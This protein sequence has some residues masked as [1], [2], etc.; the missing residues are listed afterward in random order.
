VSADPSIGFGNLLSHL[1]FAAMVA[2]DARYDRFSLL[3][4]FIYFN[5]GGTASR[6]RSINSPG[7]L[8]VPVTGGL[9]ANVGMNVQAAEWTLAGGYTLV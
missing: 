1:N 2:A 9:S 7:L 5:L 4:D 8:P 3:A 6:F